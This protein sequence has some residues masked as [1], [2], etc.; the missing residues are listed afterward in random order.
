MNID[1]AKQE[2]EEELTNCIAKKHLDVILY[3]IEMFF[4]DISEESD[5]RNNYDFN[6]CIND[7]AVLYLKEQYVNLLMCDKRCNLEKS[8]ICD[9][10]LRYQELPTINLDKI[11]FK[12]CNL[13]NAT[14]ENAFNKLEKKAQ[15]KIDSFIVKN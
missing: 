13:I 9:Y 8:T 10:I 2:F 7:Q 3:N 1:I 6:Y 4:K 5:Y 12:Y 11:Y 14:Y 15:I